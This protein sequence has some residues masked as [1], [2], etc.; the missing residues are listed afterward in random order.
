MP[1]MLLESVNVG[2]PRTESRGASHDSQEPMTSA[3]WK[4]P[5]TGSVWLGASGLLGDGVADTRIHGGPWRAVLMYSAD[6]YPRW[7]AEWNRTDLGPGDF[8]ENLTVRGIE[9]STACLGDRF[10]IGEALLEVT[11][12]RGP[13]WKLA[14]RHGV[15]D[16]VAVVKANHRHGWYLRVLRTGWIEA[17]QPA[18]LVDRPHPEWSIDRVGRV[19]W[20]RQVSEYG[21]LAACPALIPEWRD[22]LRQLAA[23]G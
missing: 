20:S 22:R 13:C 8:G 18:T 12:P 1:A 2:R 4:E 21:E 5:V 7:C 17:G 14:R 9:E 15:E 23:S 19:R 10:A 16:L 6:H 3:I 11:S